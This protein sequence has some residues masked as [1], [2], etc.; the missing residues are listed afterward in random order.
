MLALECMPLVSHSKIKAGRLGIQGQHR[1]PND[2]LSFKTNE[3]QMF[4]A[5]V[6]TR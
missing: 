2:T 1:L 4:T 3:K 5:L 6:L